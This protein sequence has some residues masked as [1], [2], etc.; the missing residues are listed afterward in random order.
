VFSDAWDT[1]PAWLTLGKVR[2]SLAQVGGGA[3]DPYGLNLTYTAQS[4]SHLGQPLMAITGN[5]IPNELKPYT[6]TTAEV[7]IET[8]IFNNMLGIDLTLYRRTTTN[9]IVNASVA[10]SSSYES[11]LLN[12]GEMRNQGIE[13]L[14]SAGP[15]T[16]ANGLTWDASFNMAYNKNKIIKIADGLNSLAIPGA[17]PRT[18]NAAIYHYEGQPFGMIAGNKTKRD[19]NGN[20]VYNNANGIPIQSEITPLGRGVPPLTLGVNNNF[21]YKNFSLS[22]LVD[23]KFGSK[24]YSSA[25]AYG[26]YFGLAKRTVENN[27]RDTGIAVRGVDQNGAEYSAVV[28]VQE[29]YQGIAY[30]I[31]DEFVYDAS[32]IKLR[33]LT[34]GYSVP[35]TVLSKTPFQYLGLSFVARNLLLLYSEV[36]NIDPES[37]YSNGNGQ[38]LENFGIPTTR[39]YGFNLLVRF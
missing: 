33:Q 37:N 7:G 22:F 2:A 14:L 28:P 13:L 5:T 31:T 1:K 3:P 25:N 10:T 29:Y 24:I 12:V 23:G 16:I 26:A 17:V 34:L 39:S 4:V 21:S 35:Q 6:S 18:E 15:L 30:S 27:V 8:K 9:D 32:F 36:P 20:I 19:A 38:G 11:V